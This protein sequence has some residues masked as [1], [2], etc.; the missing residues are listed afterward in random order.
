MELSG[1]L[2]A[3]SL[4]SNAIQ[5]WDVWLHL[6]SERF[7]EACSIILATGASS[8]AQPAGKATCRE[9]IKSKG[10][11]NVAQGFSHI[12]SASADEEGYRQD[13]S[14]ESESQPEEGIY[15]GHLERRGS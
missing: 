6:Y 3:Y 11:L 4:P 8:Q 7:K 15:R 10:H 13:S 2:C 5:W 1:M 9:V 12:G 14:F